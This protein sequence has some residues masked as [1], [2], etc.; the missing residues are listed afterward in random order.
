M[1]Q[2]CFCEVGGRTTGPGGGE[3]TEA[4]GRGMASG[5]WTPNVTCPLGLCGV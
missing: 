5:C 2:A 3:A 4:N 1:G